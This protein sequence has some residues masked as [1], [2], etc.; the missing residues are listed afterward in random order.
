MDATVVCVDRTENTVGAE[1]HTASFP[2]STWS[3][4]ELPGQRDWTCLPGAITGNGDRVFA[5]FEAYVTAKHA[6]HFILTL[7]KELGDDLIV[8]RDGTP[9]AQASAV[10]D[11][12]TR[13]DLAPA[14]S[15]PYSPDSNP[16]EECRRRLHKTLGNRWYDSLDELTTVIDT[17]LDQLSVPEV[18][19]YF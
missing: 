6:K 18:G 7:W 8:V 12:A 5:R 19:N 16:L 9:H 15:P 17:A 11:L 2:H 13:D 3:A 14:R 10:T 1:A 4:V